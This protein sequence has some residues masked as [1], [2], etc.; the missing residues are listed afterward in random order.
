MADDDGKRAMDPVTAGVE[1]R[2]ASVDGVDFGQRIITVIAVPYE[3]P[4]EVMYRQEVWNE[5]FTRTAFEGIETRNRRIPVNRE[6]KPEWLVGKVV[7]TQPHHETGLLA[8]IRISRTEHG[9]ETLELASDDA[10]SASVGMMVKEPHRD[11]VLDRH[12]RT[13]RINRAFLDHLALVGSPAYEGAKVLAMRSPQYTSDADLPPLVRPV[14]DDYLNDPV[15]RW[16]SERL[17]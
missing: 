9:D 7:G 12:T 15:F 1:I 17:Q 6:H 2:S 4:T 16:A 13:R 14:L 5:V 10:V 8:E 3:Q 11:Q